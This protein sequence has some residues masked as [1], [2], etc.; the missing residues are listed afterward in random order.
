METEKISKENPIEYIEEKIH[1]LS[2]NDWK[3]KL[4][5]RI[6]EMEKEFIIHGFS[7]SS[8]GIEWEVIKK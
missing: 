3:K 6:E 2:D 7:V 1:W 4:F 8:E 5:K